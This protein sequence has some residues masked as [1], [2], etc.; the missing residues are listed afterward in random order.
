MKF[1]KLAR[2]L[3]YDDG[4]GAT[5]LYVLSLCYNP[6]PATWLYAHKSHRGIGC[7]LCRFPR[8]ED[9]ERSN[10][11]RMQHI[12]AEEQIY[13]AYDSGS[14]ADTEQGQKVL[15]NFMASERLILKVGAQVCVN[16]PPQRVRISSTSNLLNCMNAC[17]CIGNVNQEYRRTAR[18]RQHGHHRRIHRAPKLYDKPGRP[19]HRQPRVRHHQTDFRIRLWLQ[20]LYRCACKG[21]ESRAKVAGGG[22]YR[23]AGAEYGKEED[24]GAT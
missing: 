10:G 7:C 12:K 14:I 24:V 2:P 8:R 21:S 15:T 3:Q 16:P 4:V 18:E 9:V 20:R 22:V 17:A 5:E 6:S 1:K 11:S 19:V 23:E 13:K